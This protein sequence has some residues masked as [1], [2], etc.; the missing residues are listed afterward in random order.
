M[1]EVLSKLENLE[2]LVMQ[3]LQQKSFYND[4][5]K[6]K[7]NELFEDIKNSLSE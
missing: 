1:K 7:L 6:I 5:V 4:D 2:E 3:D